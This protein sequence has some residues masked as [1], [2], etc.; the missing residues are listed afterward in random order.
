MDHHVHSFHDHGNMSFHS[1]DGHLASIGIKGLFGAKTYFDHHGHQIGHTQPNVFG[2]KDVWHGTKL[3]HVT[4]PTKTGITD[5]LH[6]DHAVHTVKIHGLTTHHQDGHMTHIF[7]TGNEFASVMNH[8]D[9]LMHVAAYKV[10][11]IHFK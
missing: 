3:T 4:A 1:V 6:P 8:S 7:H 9:P 11:P 10:P 5:L 2:G